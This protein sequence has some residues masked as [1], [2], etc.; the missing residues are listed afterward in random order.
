MEVTYLSTMLEENT[1]HFIY[2]QTLTFIG[3]IHLNNFEYLYHKNSY[4]LYGM[5]NNKKCKVAIK[6]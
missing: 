5:S 4:I 2:T 1:D 6:L 3:S